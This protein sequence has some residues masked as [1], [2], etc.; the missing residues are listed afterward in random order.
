M[1]VNLLA[2]L[3]WL[4]R[5]RRLDHAE[6]VENSEPSMTKFEH[7]TNSGEPRSDCIM[8]EPVTH[9]DSCRLHAAST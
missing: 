7:Q 2:G 1:Y 9:V 3:S 5:G 4:T 6:I 8:I